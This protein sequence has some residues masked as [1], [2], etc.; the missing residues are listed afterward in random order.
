MGHLAGD[1]IDF[2]R[3][4]GRDDHIRIARPGPVQHIRIG[5]ETRHPLNIQRIDRAADQI[6]IVINHG[7]VVFLLR[8][9][10]GDLPAHLAGTADNDFHSNLLPEPPD[11]KW[12][13]RG[14]ASMIRHRVTPGP[15]RVPPRGHCTLTVHTPRPSARGQPSSATKATRP[16]ALLAVTTPRLFSLRCRAER[17]MPT[18]VAVREILPP[19]RLI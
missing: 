14:L 8:Q 19:N 2:I 4:G 5:G 15:A 18:K 11:L 3:I 9:M 12:Q 16:P 7:H 17:S 10:A 6:G 1:H 13:I